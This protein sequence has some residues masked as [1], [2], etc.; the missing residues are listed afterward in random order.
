MA[1]HGD[2]KSLAEYIA[3]GDP[4]DPEDR[5][6]LADYVVGRLKRGR[7]DR[8]ISPVEAEMT[9]LKKWMF[10][11]AWRGKTHKYYGPQYHGWHRYNVT[12]GYA[13][14]DYER[15]KGVWRTRYKRKNPL[16]PAALAA[17]AKRNGVDEDK[18]SQ[19]IN[20]STKNPAVKSAI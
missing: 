6:V 9:K 4:L 19:F 17:A 1:V 20:R 8:G 10:D 16:Q 5:K 14:I 12:F 13:A 18:L 15:F 3:S 11:G 7:G 2:P